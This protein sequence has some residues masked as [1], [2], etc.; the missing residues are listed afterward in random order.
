MACIIEKELA[1]DHVSGYFW[2]DSQ[3]VMG[4]IGNTQRRLKIFVASRVQQIRE[5]SDIRQWN[6]VPSKMNPADHASRGVSRSNS[7]HLDLWLNDLQFLWKS[8][9]QWPKQIAV[10]IDNNDAEIKTEI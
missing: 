6:Y 2:T 9:F 7:K 10:D 8:E 5:Y 1:I 4:Y 3:V